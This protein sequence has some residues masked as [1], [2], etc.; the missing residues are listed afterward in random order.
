MRDKVSITLPFIYNT[1]NLS[2][3]HSTTQNHKFNLLE[4]VSIG[5]LWTT[6]PG[7]T[8]QL[9]SGDR[10]REDLFFLFRWKRKYHS[11]YLD[12]TKVSSRVSLFLSLSHFHL[13]TLQNFY[14]KDSDNLYMSQIFF[15]DFKDIY[16]IKCV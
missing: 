12:S 14:S 10:V 13:C 7:L 9:M 11:F 16:R 15:C 5:Q 4:G 1:N 6:E 3:L 8:R 2:D